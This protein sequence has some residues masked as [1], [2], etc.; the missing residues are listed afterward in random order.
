MRELSL[1]V[2]DIAQNSV[3]AGSSLVT[4]EAI[5]NTAKHELTLCVADNGKGMTKEQLDAVRDPFFTTRTTRKVGLGIPLFK[6]AAEMTGG[7]LTI[8]SELGKGT[9]V[10]AVF[11]TNHVDFTPLGDM[12]STIV[13]LITM[14]THI[15]FVYHFKKDKYEFSLDTRKL[16]EILGEVSLSEPSIAQ[17]L[18]EYINE[19]TNV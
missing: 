7:A 12:T 18:T 6:M 16:K 4:V 8:E 17:W 15:D 11:K 2:L 10:T 1:N 19:N 14:N 9:T 13:A 5:E 3:A